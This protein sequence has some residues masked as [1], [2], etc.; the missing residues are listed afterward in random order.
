[1]DS[2]MKFNKLVIIMIEIIPIKHD[3]TIYIQYLIAKTYLR[4]SHRL[5]STPYLLPP[6]M[7]LPVVIRSD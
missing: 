3:F 7:L 2:F 6:E 1:M 4:G 5:H